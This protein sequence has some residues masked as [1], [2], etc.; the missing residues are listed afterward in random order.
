LEN[1]INGVA[2]A[3]KTLHVV[4]ADTD[5]ECVFGVEDDIDKS[6]AIHFEIVDKEARFRDGARILNANVGFYQ[7]N[8]SLA[9]FIAIHVELLPG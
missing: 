7:I 1:E 2:N 9:D 6:R 3:L 5:F 8:K 4:I